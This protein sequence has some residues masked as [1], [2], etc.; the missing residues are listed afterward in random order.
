MV[1]LRNRDVFDHAAAI[2]IGL[3]AQSAL[4]MRAAH[5][6]VA[7]KDVAH[8]ARNLAAD[9]D[10]AVAVLHGAIP[11]TIMFSHG[12]LTRRPSPLR[13]DLMAMQS[14]PVSKVQF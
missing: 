13:P 2:G 6:A 8:A 1:T 7:D 12:T 5:A 10:A 11:S 3:D 14:S 9:A 4:E